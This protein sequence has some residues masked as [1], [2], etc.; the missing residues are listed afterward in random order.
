[1]KAARIVVLMIAIGAGGVAYVLS[2]GRPATAPAA[3]PVAKSIDTVDILVA[4]RDIGV[5]QRLLIDD[6]GWQ[7]WPLAAAGDGM[8]RESNRPDAVKDFTGA[9]ARGTFTAGEPIREQKLIRADGSGFMSAILPE[10]MR[11]VSAEVAEE[12][13][14]GGFVLPNDRVDVMLTRTDPESQKN[15]T[16]LVTETILTNV[17]VLAI[18]QVIEDKEGQ[19]SVAGKATATLELSPRQSEILASASENGTLS[20]ALRSLAD[21]SP[22]GPGSPEREANSLNI[23]RYGVPSIATTR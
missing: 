12:K 4:K 5:G 18:G 21:S 23:V 17:R 1:M 2:R 20:L 9:V 11:A 6:L 14:A 13:R 22:T 15:G 3:A 19:R 8:I 16:G 10:G 7:N